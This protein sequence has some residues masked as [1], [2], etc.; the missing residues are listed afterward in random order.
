M[1]SLVPLN[2]IQIAKIMKG[3]MIFRNPNLSII[4]SLK[5]HLR[6][7]WKLEM[8]TKL[9]FD[10]VRVCLFPWMQV[11]VIN[12]PPVLTNIVICRCKLDEAVIKW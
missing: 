6:S 11:E 2:T 12:I 7:P 8:T 4:L 5:T 3:H 1:V 10:F 9:V